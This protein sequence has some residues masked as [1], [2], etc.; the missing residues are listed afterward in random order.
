MEHLFDDRTNNEDVKRMRLSNNKS[1]VIYRQLFMTAFLRQHVIY[2]HDLFMS[3]AQLQQRVHRRYNL[4]H[5]LNMRLNIWNARS[6]LIC[7]DDDP[8]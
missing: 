1:N 5:A 8:L 6:I 7:I 4:K 2:Q 3:G